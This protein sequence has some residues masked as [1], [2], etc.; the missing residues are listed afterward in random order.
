MALS[1][2][3]VMPHSPLL[4]PNI[5]QEHTAHFI[6]TLP[7][8]NDLYKII[9]T[10]QVNTIIIISAQGHIFPQGLALNVSLDFRANL[11]MF[12][13]LVTRWDFN[14]D[15]L[16]AGRLREHLENK[17]NIRLITDPGLDYGSAIPLSLLNLPLKQKILPLT[18]DPSL[19]LEKII[20]LGKILQPLII[21][22]SEKIAVIASADLSHR[23]NKKS[24]HGY[25]PKSK[26]FDQKIIETLK[27]KDQISLIEL[28][29]QKD[30]V[31][32]EDLSTLALL[33]GILDDV[34]LEAKLL[35][36]EAP[37]GVGHCLMQYDQPVY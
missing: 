13:D 15:I 33:L 30:E 5:G 19:D 4:A 17:N 8:G 1:L 14:G 12:G 20:D 26:K 22:D 3:A 36:Y 25:S 21:D 11:E 23:L 31:A 28:A 7:A 10:R 9:E 29:K 35:S 18:V 24:P 2:A 34:G 37:F 27:T 32:C 6:T 16:L